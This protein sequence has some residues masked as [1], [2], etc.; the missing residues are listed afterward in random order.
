MYVK[1]ESVRLRF[2]ALNQT[3]MRAEN[4]IH[5][6][7]AIRNDA[8]LD[9]NNLDQMVIPPSSFVNSARYLHE[10]TQEAYTYLSN[11]GRPD[12][13][14]TMACNPAWSEI[15]RELNPG[16]NSKDRHDLIAREFKIKVQKLVALLTKGKISG[17][18]KCFMYSI[19][20][21]KGLPHVHLLL[22]LMEK[23]RSNQIDKVISAEIPNPETQ[24][25]LYD[26]VTKNMIHGFCGALNPSSPC[27]KEGKCTK[28]YPRAL[29]KH[30]QTNDKGSPLYRCR[31]P[32]DNGHPIIQK[33]R[34]R[35]Q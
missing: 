4:Y 35:K 8:D 16:Q 20:W 29:L 19:E 10:Y 13:F 7:E 15:I 18:M 25:K 22:W 17:D 2:I 1:V 6:Q 31:S 5:L 33:T 34:G 30:T 28:K 11:Y 32:E 26:T 27:M 9:L 3:K 12:L 14:I 21:Q 23:L 24:R